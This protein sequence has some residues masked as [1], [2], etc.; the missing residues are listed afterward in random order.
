MAN[1]DFIEKLIQ[2]YETQS[3]DILTETYKELE[4]EG[5]KL[6]YDDLFYLNQKLNKFGYQARW[7]GVSYTQK[8]S[9]TTTKT[10]P[11]LTYVK[12]KSNQEF[13]EIEMY[14]NAGMDSTAIRGEVYIYDDHAVGHLEG[15]KKMKEM[16]YKIITSGDLTAQEIR[17]Q[18]DSIYSGTRNSKG[19]D[20]E[21]KKRQIDS[22][23]ASLLKKQKEYNHAQTQLMRAKQASGN[24]T[25]FSSGR[26]DVTNPT[27]TKV[28]TIKNS[29]PSSYG[30]V[31][32]GVTSIVPN[33]STFKGNI[34]P[35]QMP[36][37]PTASAFKK[38]QGIKTTKSQ[39]RMPT[40]SIP[41]NQTPVFY[42]I[43]TIGDLGADNFG[44][45]QYTFRY[46]T[47][48][49]KVVEWSPIVKQEGGSV[50]LIQEVVRKL[51]GNILL[52]PTEERTAMWLRDFEVKVEPSTQKGKPR[53]TIIPSHKD[54]KDVNLYNPTTIQEIKIGANALIGDD[55][56]FSNR[57]GGSPRDLIKG[58]ASIGVTNATGEVSKGKV[59]V[60]QNNINFDDRDLV[61]KGVKI[62][63][64]SFD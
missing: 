54:S 30:H 15:T 40:A 33:V 42:D 11:E 34:N 3:S 37:M 28:K 16:E 36:K 5:T 25:P 29:S 22:R 8:S 13:S 47:S 23:V 17:A 10:V 38:M 55:Y 2:G 18:L 52:S 57:I 50:K 26:K 9:G 59:L 64:K 7:D 1:N 63:N 45:T 41:K 60:G 19:N 53:A 46:Q 48:K 61:S 4:K 56:V 24:K 27:A 14:Q 44:V 12:K 58:L 35:D 6:L 62:G 43:E 31:T 39:L 20:Q 21:T 51:E 32:G 49:G